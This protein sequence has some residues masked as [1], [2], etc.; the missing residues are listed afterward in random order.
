M[1][2]VVR[3]NKEKVEF[4]FQ[5]DEVEFKNSKDE[6]IGTSQSSNLVVINSKDDAVKHLEFEIQKLKDIIIP[7]QA[8]LDLM[9]SKFDIP[10]L[11]DV[12]DSIIKNKGQT[13]AAKYKKI[14]GFITQHEQMK[15]LEVDIKQDNE[16]LVQLQENLDKV[17]KLK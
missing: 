10:K 3:K 16:R 6:V 9:R 7:K 15:S 17:N 11:N 13:T 5:N 2:T 4:L 8:R 12:C 1:E 14:E